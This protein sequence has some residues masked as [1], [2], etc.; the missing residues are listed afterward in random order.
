MIITICSSMHFRDKII[1]VKEYLEKLGYEVLTPDLGRRKSR[2]ES[3]KAKVQNELIRKHFKKIEKSDAVLILN[4][5]KDDKA[6]H[7][8]GNVFLEMGKAFDREIPIFV[9]NPVPDVNY[10]DEIAAM[11]PIVINGK[12]EVMEEV[13]KNPPGRSYY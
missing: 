12:W 10:K 2:I 7:I 6:N 5:T 1:Q 4:Y 11:Q 13:L 9:M 3:L 8:G